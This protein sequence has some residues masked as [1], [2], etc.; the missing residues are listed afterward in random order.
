MTHPFTHNGK[1]PLE[2]FSWC[3]MPCRLF[4]NSRSPKT[5][6]DQLQLCR[7]LEIFS[8]LQTV[9]IHKTGRGRFVY[10][11]LWLSYQYQLKKNDKIKCKLFPT[12]SNRSST[13]QILCTIGI[14]FC[15]RCD[16]W[17]RFPASDIIIITIIIMIMINRLWYPKRW[18]KQWTVFSS[19]NRSSI[20]YKRECISSLRRISHY[21]IHLKWIKKKNL[22]H[23]CFC[24]S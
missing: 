12:Y 18:I 3:L 1:S 14:D 8:S 17:V 21:E 2:W 24:Q 15:R 16:W 6:T 10:S 13:V 20:W 7:A 9:I 19:F 11:C 5:Y 23:L 4:Q 22:T